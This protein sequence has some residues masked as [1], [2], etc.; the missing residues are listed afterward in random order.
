MP[1]SHHWLC[2]CVAVVAG[3]ALPGLAG[4]SDNC[5]DACPAKRSLAECGDSPSVDVDTLLAHPNEDLDTTM[6]VSGTIGQEAGVCTQLGCFDG[7]C[8]ACGARLTVNGSAGHAIALM[9]TDAG[10]RCGGD[11]SRICC[12]LVMGAKVV[13]TGHF[14]K[15]SDTLDGPTFVLE[16]PVVCAAIRTP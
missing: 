11:E 8:N 16:Q 13:V 12:P 2:M 7:C 10:L 1:D 9:S 4:C 5:L 15:E 3:A 6:G 14:R